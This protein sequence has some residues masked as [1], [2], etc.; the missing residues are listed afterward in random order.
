[1]V[2]MEIESAWTYR[3]RPISWDSGGAG[4]HRIGC[5]VF[6][7]SDL[8]EIFDK[9]YTSSG[10]VK[11]KFH[12]AIQLANQLASCFASCSATC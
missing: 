7:G 8:H 5:G 11:A 3:R 10:I 1:M 9:V 6:Y 2:A 12:Y 4:P